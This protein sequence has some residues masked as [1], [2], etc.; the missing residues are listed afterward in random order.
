MTFRAADIPPPTRT[1]VPPPSITGID[2]AVGLEPT[3]TGSNTKQER[4]NA[5]YCARERQW[6]PSPP[7]CVHCA[8]RGLLGPAR[9]RTVFILQTCHCH[10]SFSPRPRVFF[11][12]SLSRLIDTPTPPHAAETQRYVTRRCVVLKA[13]D[14]LA[15]RVFFCW[16]PHLSVGVFSPPVLK[17]EESE[18]S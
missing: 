2:G 7:A 5:A 10:R 6:R 3:G 15:L 4:K 17:I 14:C 12:L 1:S 16:A 13:L 9:R 11:S 8:R 18:R